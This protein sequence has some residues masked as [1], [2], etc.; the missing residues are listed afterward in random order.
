MSDT[1]AIF[2]AN[3]VQPNILC[4][5]TIEHTTS[6]IKYT[7]CYILD[8]SEVVQADGMGGYNCL[9]CDFH[10]TKLFNMKRHWDSKHGAPVFYTCQYCYKQ[11][12][13]KNGLDTHISRDH[14]SK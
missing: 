3:S 10:S 4:L 9:N 8:Y 13:S 7:Q 1:S 2:A 5:N 14:S 11:C 6:N 12:K